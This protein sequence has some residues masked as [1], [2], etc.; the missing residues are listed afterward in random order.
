M[1]R[2][3]TKLWPF[4]NKMRFAYQYKSFSSLILPQPLVNLQVQTPRFGDLQ[5]TFLLDSG[6]DVTILPLKPYA[7]LFDFQPGDQAVSIK[8]IGRSIKGYPYQ[9][10]LKLFNRWQ[11]VDCYLVNT[12]TL[13]LLG[14]QDIWRLTN[15]MFDNQAQ[16]T[17]LQAI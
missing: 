16:Q 14:R 11:T 17:V 6:A 2:W 10:K 9:L 1:W 4:G 12:S 3:L 7:S 13:P 15:V 5:I 8:G